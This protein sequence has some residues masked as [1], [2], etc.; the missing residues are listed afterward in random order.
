MWYVVV[1]AL[2]ELEREI[3]LSVGH[4]S[5]LGGRGGKKSTGQVPK[6]SATQRAT[7]GTG[8]GAESWC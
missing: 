6:A 1:S 8:G 2:G 4:F 7:E 3:P 5:A